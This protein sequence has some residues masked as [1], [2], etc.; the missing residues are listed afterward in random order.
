MKKI[1]IIMLLSVFISS[2]ITMDE[3]VEDWPELKITAHDANLGMINEKCWPSIPLIKK[4]MGSVVLGCAI[5]DLDKKTCDIYVAPN[6]PKFILDHEIEHCLGD[7]HTDGSQEEFLNHWLDNNNMVR[8][9]SSLFSAP[10]IVKD[11]LGHFQWDHSS[12][13]GAIPKEFLTSAEAICKKLDTKELTYKAI[14]FH[15]NAQDL[16]GKTFLAG[17]YFCVPKQ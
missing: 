4:M 7:D 15:P 9:H 17:G 3:H 6:A 13:F 1:I 11:L 10:K 12:K 16:N 2:C 5:Y 8:E 14:G